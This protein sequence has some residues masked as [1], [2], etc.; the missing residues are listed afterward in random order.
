MTS[1][2]A[3]EIY[4]IISDTCAVELYMDLIQKAVVYAHIRAEW[5][6]AD[7]KTQALLRASRTAAHNAFI[8]A[9]GALSLA[10]AENEESSSWHEHIGNDRQES[11]EFACWMHYHLSMEAE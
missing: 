11:A 10:M 9:T 4:E 7:E 5:A 3:R 8:A 6:L 1:K 2:L